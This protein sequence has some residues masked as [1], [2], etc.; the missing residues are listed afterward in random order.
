MGFCTASL[1]EAKIVSNNG[2]CRSFADMK[3]SSSSKPLWVIVLLQL[4]FLMNAT[5]AGFV[6]GQEVYV[7]SSSVNVRLKP[8]ANAAVSASIPIGT[9]VEYRGLAGTAV[10]QNR[11]CTGNK[12]AIDRMWS[13]ICVPGLQYQSDGTGEYGKPWCGWVRKE[14]LSIKKPNLAHLIARYDRAEDVNLVERKKLAEQA[15]ALAPFSDKAKDILIEALENLKDSA[16]VEVTKRR[17]KSYADQ[18][19]EEVEP[20]YIFSMSGENLQVVAEVNKGKVVFI[21]PYTAAGRDFG[22]LKSGMVLLQY[23]QGKIVGSVLTMAQFN[24]GIKKC[25]FN[26]IVRQI[27]GAPRAKP[28]GSLVTNFMLPERSNDMFRTISKSESTL[29]KSMA[30]ASFKTHPSDDKTVAL[31]RKHIQQSKDFAALKIGYIGKDGR[32]MLIGNWE[33]GSAAGVQYGDGFHAS[34]FIIA[35]KQSD[36]SFKRVAV[37]NKVTENGCGYWDHTDTDGDG[38][39]EILLTCHQLEGQ[40][41]YALLKRINGKWRLKE[42]SDWH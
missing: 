10:N 42:S 20:K 25:A 17:F 6:D 18:E 9:K 3:H 23:E 31:F 22:F 38:V 29:L 40:Y 35:E 5:A 33:M 21:D 13:C 24:C 14:E 11:E 30:R 1:G 7:V 34:L 8:S 4:V 16:E 27:S 37:P 15:F 41:N 12:P 2:K 28:Y 39:D 19:I 36:G 26:T 32:E